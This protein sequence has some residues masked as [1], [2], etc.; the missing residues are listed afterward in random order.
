ML[1]MSMD[2]AIGLALGTVTTF[3]TFDCMVVG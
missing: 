1:H 3:G 2:I